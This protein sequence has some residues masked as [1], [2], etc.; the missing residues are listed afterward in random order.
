[1]A[2]VGILAAIATVALQNAVDRAKQR[3][4]MA[5]MRSIAMALE[6]YSTDVGPYPAP[7]LTMDQLGQILIPYETS[8]LR[9]QDHWKHD[10]QYSY[11]GAKSYSVESFGKDGVDGSNISYGTRFEFDRDLILSNGLFVASP[12]S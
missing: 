2:I 5:D 7:G 1:M 12:E 9:T 11:D 6:A 10:Y 4:T 8:V 3:G